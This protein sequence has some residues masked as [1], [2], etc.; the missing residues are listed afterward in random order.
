MGGE[1]STYGVKQRCMKGFRGENLKED[2]EGPGVDESP[3]NGVWGH[4]LDRSNSGQ[5]QLA[6]TCECGN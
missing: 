2:L 5:E 1:C 4:R 3:G 6:G